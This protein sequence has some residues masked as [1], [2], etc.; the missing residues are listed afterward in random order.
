MPKW[1]EGWDVRVVNY[2]GGYALSIPVEVI[3]DRHDPVLAFAEAKVTLINGIGRLLGSKFRPVMVEGTIYGLDSDGAKVN[4]VVSIQGAEVRMR[5]SAVGVLSG[6]PVPLDPAIGAAKPLL[7]AASNLPKAHDA[8]TIIGRKDLT[9]PE[10]YLL[11]ELVQSDVGGEMHKLGWVSKAEAELF[12]HTA[13]SYSALRSEGRHGKDIGRPPN[14]PMERA[15][16][17]TFIRTLVLAWLRSRASN[18][19]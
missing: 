11:F 15:A 19:K 8:L 13:N 18:G 2:E 14:T 10:L 1:L 4:T 12:C 5:L 16:A 9:W 17:V 7:T 6:G 3:G